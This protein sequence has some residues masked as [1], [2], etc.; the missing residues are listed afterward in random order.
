[1]HS[2]R[3]RRRRH[4]RMHHRLAIDTLALAMLVA[5]AVAIAAEDSGDGL[6]PVDRP[7]A[8]HLEL[9]VLDLPFQSANGRSWPSMQ[10]SL[11]VTADL[12]QG[13]HHLLGRLV[14][15]HAS[16]WKEALAGKVIITL[17]DIFTGTVPGLLA[18]Q[19]EEWHRAVMSWRG[20]GSYDDIYNLRLLAEIVNVSHV[21][22]ENLVR[23][24]AEHPADQVRMSMAGIEGNY[25]EAHAV[26]SIQFFQHTTTWNPA[27]LWVLYIG[28]SEYLRLCASTRSDT[29]TMMENDTEG[30]DVPRRDFTGLDCDGWTYDLFRPD[31]PY[32]ARGTHPSGVGIDRYRSYSRLAPEEQRFTRRQHLLSYLNFLDPNLIGVQRMRLPWLVGGAPVDFNLAFRYVPAAFGYDLRLDLFGQRTQAQNLLVSLHGYFNHGGP[33]P[34]LEVALYRLP[35]GRL[36]GKPLLLGV[37]AAGWLQPERL[38]YDSNGGDVGGLV[39]VRA[40]WALLPACEPYLEVETKSA[41]WVTGNVFLDANL[42][43]RTGLVAQF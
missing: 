37:R 36:A 13:V 38:R 40:G 24:K 26:E 8:V 41:G 17:F 2:A 7:P 22:D 3:E 18:W 11:W 43:A 20:V 19:H 1:M 29:T 28:N 23:L 9:P 21:T 31:E 16:G 10:Q 27:L 32:A 33:F 35:V 4:Q 25:A 30:A 14:D 42:S 6:A 5:P 15:P 39:G 34:G 12:Y